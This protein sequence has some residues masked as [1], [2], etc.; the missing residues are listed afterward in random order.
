MRARLRRRERKRR[1]RKVN[2]LRQHRRRPRASRPSR[3]PARRRRLRTE[4]PDAHAALGS[5]GRG[6][7]RTHVT[8]GESRRALPIHGIFDETGRGGDVARTHGERRADEDDPR[9][10]VG[11]RRCT[12]GG[13]AAGNGRRAD[14]DIAEIAADGRGGGEHAAR[15][16]AGGREKRDR[17]V[18]E[19]EHGGGG[20]GGEYGVLL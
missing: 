12:H 15:V 1:R 20:S 13:H 8:D 9:H 18:R 14:F 6:R 2:H 4:R 16:G 5:A 17:Y 19:S 7:G 3:R 11:R 10:E